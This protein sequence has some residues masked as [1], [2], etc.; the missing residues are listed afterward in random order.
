MASQET[1]KETKK[2]CVLALLMGLLPAFE[3]RGPTCLFC[4]GPHILCRWL[5][6]CHCKQRNRFGKLPVSTKAEHTQQGL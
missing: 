2:L 4:T 6:E 1:A 3:T 5:C